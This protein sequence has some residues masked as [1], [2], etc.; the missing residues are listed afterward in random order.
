MSTTAPEGTTSGDDDQRHQEATV[1]EPQPTRIVPDRESFQHLQ[2]LED[3]IDY[4]T[5]RLVLPC[6]SCSSDGADNKCDEHAVDVNLVAA[7]RRTAKSRDAEM[8]AARN[9]RAA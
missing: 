5:A 8:T 7:Y 3:A 2:A 4:R 6:P 9:R 1:E